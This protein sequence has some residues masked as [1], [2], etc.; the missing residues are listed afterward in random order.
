MK[1]PMKQSP[2]LNCNS[3]RDKRQ[4]RKTK[5]LRLQAKEYSYA[6]YFL[7]NPFDS[8]SAREAFSKV[9]S[10]K[11]RVYRKLEQT[12]NIRALTKHL[13]TECVAVEEE[14]SKKKSSWDQLLQSYRIPKAGHTERCNDQ[15][16][17]YDRLSRQSEQCD[18]H[19]YFTSDQTDSL[20]SIQHDR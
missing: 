13:H 11:S 20:E 15:T 4:S 17:V 14:R 1:I 18:R 6:C 9:T 3:N 10:T 7:R 19:N 8:Y 16:C 12:A 2:T 5:N